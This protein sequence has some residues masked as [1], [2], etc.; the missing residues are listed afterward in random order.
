MSKN[1]NL[2]KKTKVQNI[3]DE[4]EDD[5]DDV[6]LQQTYRSTRDYL[7]GGR[8]THR[9]SDESTDINER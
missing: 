2:K 3:Y 8:D 9:L 5:D 7:T 6:F 1:Q 4:Y